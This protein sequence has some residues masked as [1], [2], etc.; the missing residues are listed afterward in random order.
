MENLD[1]IILAAG[2]GTRM[3]GDLPKVLNQAQGK[4]MLYYTIEAVRKSG[5]PHEPVIVVGYKGELVKDFVEGAL[6]EKSQARFAH[7]TEQRGTGHAVMSARDIVRQDAE[8]ILIL[9]GDQPLVR[10]ES[11]K[12]IHD[13]HRAQKQSPIT[14]A[15]V[16]VDSFDGWKALF[17]DFG[18]IVRDD[19]GEI[20]AIVEKKDTTE[21]QK[22][23]MELNPAYFCVDAGWLWE[24]LDQV[25]TK[26]AQGEYYLTDLIGIAQKQGYTIASVEIPAE[27]ALGVNTPE[28]LAHVEFLMRMR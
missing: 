3:G 22:K 6:S 17:A 5:L 14:M 24:S 9:Y 15:T 2:K 7:Q 13:Y 18:R 12:A 11:L 25:T 21:D 1:I 20:F 19:Q 26:N 27:D 16:R 10:A 8:S 4:P 23:I 28:Q